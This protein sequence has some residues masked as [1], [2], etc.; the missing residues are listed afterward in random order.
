MTENA[1]NETSKILIPELCLVAMVGASSSGKSTFARKHFKPTEILSS[2]FFRG[3]ISD[4]ES[5]QAASSGA[6]ELLHLAA[7]KRLEMGKLTV[8]DATSL[9]AR[10]RDQIMKNAREQNV[11]A[12]AIVLNLPEKVI[13]E[14]NKKEEN[15]IY[16]IY[17]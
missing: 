11:Q 14:R 2:D 6:F 16:L 9:K 4:D 3:M 13:Q 17:K 15:Q 12:V 10:D 5:N 1:K 7:A 8:I